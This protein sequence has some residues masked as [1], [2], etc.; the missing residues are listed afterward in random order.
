M[1]TYEYAKGRR[2]LSLIRSLDTV[3]LERKHIQNPR[4]SDSYLQIFE[5]AQANLQG[6][7]LH[8][9]LLVGPASG[10][11]LNVVL[12]LPNSLTKAPGFEDEQWVG[13]GTKG[14]TLRMYSDRLSSLGSQ[15]RT[16]SK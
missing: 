14:F 6:A 2:R 1:L 7:C 16:A 15:N 12:I 3:A 9:L 11:R 10:W 8:R 5:A 4:F 13:L